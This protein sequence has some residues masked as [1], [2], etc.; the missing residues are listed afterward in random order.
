MEWVK[1]DIK[2]KTFSLSAD[3]AVNIS[4]D[5][6]KQ[7]SQHC[8]E[9]GKIIFGQPEIFNVIGKRGVY[10]KECADHFLVDA[11]VIETGKVYE[12]AGE[13]AQESKNVEN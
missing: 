2:G 9:C 3:N 12:D 7:L 8:W 10:C 11:E 1:I 6:Q 5:I 4:T 13:T